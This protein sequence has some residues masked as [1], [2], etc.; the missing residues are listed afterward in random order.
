MKEWTFLG[1]TDKPTRDVPDGG[2]LIAR[3]SPDEFLVTGR[4]ARVSFGPGK[5]SSKAKGFIFAR[6]EEGHFD[7]DGQ[8]I[9][10]R[11]WNGDQTD[12]GL[13]FSSL[14]QLLR[15]RVASY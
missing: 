5:S 9:F 7:A 15:V 8:W 3:L 6:V 4:N 2:A 11:V 13:N 10:E 1:N 14:P 12:Y